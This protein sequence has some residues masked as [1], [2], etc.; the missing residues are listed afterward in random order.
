[1]PALARATERRS[2][3][4]ATTP[5]RDRTIGG[6]RSRNEAHARSVLG[7]TTPHDAG[8]TAARATR[9]SP[10]APLILPTLAADLPLEI[11]LSDREGVVSTIAERLVGAGIVTRADVAGMPDPGEAI[12]LAIARRAG[13]DLAKLS[14]FQLQLELR[15]LS[16]DPYN[17]GNAAPT[18]DALTGI[19][20]VQD[21]PI[22]T[23]GPRL[24]HLTHGNVRAAKAVL[25]YF[26]RAQCFGIP[27]FTPD[28]AFYIATS[29]H[30]QGEET[31]REFLAQLIAMGED[32]KHY[33]IL[34]EVDLYRHMPRW[35][36]NPGWSNP[37]WYKAM[38]KGRKAWQSVDPLRPWRGRIDPRLVALCDQLAE[39]TYPLVNS[40]SLASPEEFQDHDP[41]FSAI[42]R[43]DERDMVPRMFD[44]WGEGHQNA[45]GDYTAGV[46][47][48]DTRDAKALRTSFNTLASYLRLMGA[49][50]DFL[51][52]LR[53]DQCP[54]P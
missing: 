18:S 5:G 10:A 12:E 6:L 37:D 48:M 41:C 27:M 38:R 44:D 46:I 20:T 53:S 30:W 17:F 7:I 11:G 45:G 25:A 34:R 23:I 43:W 16:V 52:Y 47:V 1:M 2:Q 50:D 3:R 28:V 4:Q 33:E 54:S 36:L 24:I 26:D 19:F 35:A 31:S 15:N 22:V 29:S 49:I 9:P 8:G 39:R 42:V 13:L 32:A 40:T 51:A 21:F 14:V